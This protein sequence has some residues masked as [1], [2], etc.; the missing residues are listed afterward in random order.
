MSKKNNSNQQEF[1]RF[2]DY[3]LIGADVNLIKNFKKF[4]GDFN[5]GDMLLNHMMQG[6]PSAFQYVGGI[7]VNYNMMRKFV[8]ST[9]N[10]KLLKQFHQ[11]GSFKNV[12][13]QRLL[14]MSIEHDDN[15]VS[16]FI[17]LI[18]NKHDYDYISKA[19]K[20]SYALK[21][22]I[23]N[24]NNSNNLFFNRPR[25]EMIAYIVDNDVLNH[26]SNAHV[27]LNGIEELRNTWPYNDE[28]YPMFISTL[29]SSY[30]NMYCYDVIVEVLKTLNGENDTYC[31]NKILAFNIVTNDY[32]K[33]LEFLMEQAKIK[34]YL[35]NSDT[36]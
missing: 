34:A 28:D 17:S 29:M 21:T 2:I 10:I 18:D 36:L 31:A 15:D 30:D 13:H 32:D 14:F 12:L 11:Y 1:R 19:Y 6:A 24:A 33:P 26:I 16:G 8:N 23:D 20:K 7:E 22:L 3:A 35:L 9:V 27:T 4:A 25:N 5:S